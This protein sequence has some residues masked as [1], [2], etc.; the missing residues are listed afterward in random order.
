MC[1]QC[2]Y[3]DAL[4]AFLCISHTEISCCI[5][6]AACDFGI[7]LRLPHHGKLAWGQHSHF[8][9]LGNERHDPKLRT[10]IR[11]LIY[12]LSSVSK[13]VGWRGRCGGVRASERAGEG[14]CGIQMFCLTRGN[15]VPANR[16][17]NPLSSFI[18]CNLPCVIELSNAGESRGRGGGGATGRDSGDTRP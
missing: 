16:S 13:A 2:T 15:S 18:K 17:S 1:E 9:K 7:L 3:S 4:S 8:Q 14:D 12:S 6:K 11:T 10:L 5:S